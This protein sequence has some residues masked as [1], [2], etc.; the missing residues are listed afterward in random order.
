M[1]RKPKA[2]E[3]DPPEQLS[4]EAR[5]R[6]LKWCKARYP[7]YVKQLGTMWLTCRDHHEARGWRRVNWEP[8]FRNWIRMAD[9]I[10]RE[11]QGNRKR[12]K[13]QEQGKRGELLRLVFTD[14]KEEEKG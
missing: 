2:P 14:E 9:K 10:D 6:V 5:A 4:P 7:Q 11:R 1:P 12:E 13:P 3:T 8:A